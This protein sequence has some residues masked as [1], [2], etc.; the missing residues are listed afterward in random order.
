MA[1]NVIR[2]NTP[3]RFSDGFS[4]QEFEELA[5]QLGRKIKRIT[6]IW[7]EGATVH[8]TVESLKHISQWNF[9][10][11]FNDWGHVTGTFWTQSGN[12]DSSIP[13][14]F[15]MTLS[16]WIHQALREK[17]IHIRDMSDDV[18]RHDNLDQL[19][20]NG[21]HSNRGFWRYVGDEVLGNK[22]Y[23][24][25]NHA[26][27]DMCGEHL[28]PIFA[29][30]MDNGF[31]NIT[32]QALK[33]VDNNGNHYEFEVFQVS[34]AGCTSFEKGKTFAYNSDVIITYHAKKEIVI[35][36]QIRSLKRQ[37]YITAGDRLQELG[38]TNIYER[39]VFC[40]RAT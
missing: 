26:N 33:D 38:F 31:E 6:K 34:I 32:V 11:D 20:A 3:C 36:F 7:V 4:Q 1:Y 14:S 2:K 28:Y 23:I 8:C 29:Q 27:W 24:S 16:G 10:V 13:H 17:D 18:E 22:R 9:S 39:M 25:V 40:E 37:N 21:L 35:P 12:H 5:L 15:G 19:I 30:L